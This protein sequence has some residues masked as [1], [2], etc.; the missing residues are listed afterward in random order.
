MEGST[1]QEKWED[2]LLYKYSND[3][4]GPPIGDQIFSRLVMCFSLKW[5]SFVHSH[6]DKKSWCGSFCIFCDSEGLKMW[7][8]PTTEQ[9][10]DELLFNLLANYAGLI[11]LRL[12][13]P[14]MRIF[15]KQ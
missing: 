9:S 10:Y 11:L 1:F 3:V 6:V 4:S 15:W 13:A 2:D 8:I 12:L 5:S 14:K 7:N